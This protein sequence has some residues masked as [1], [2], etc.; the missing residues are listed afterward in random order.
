[1]MFEGFGVS[2]IPFVHDAYC[3]CGVKLKEVSNGLLSKAMYC[4]KCENVYLLK[5]VKEPKKKISKEFLNQCREEVT[6]KAKKDNQ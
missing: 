6:T 5:L 2:A 1:M 3:K 4:P